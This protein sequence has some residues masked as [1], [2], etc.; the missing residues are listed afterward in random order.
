[1]IACSRVRCDQQVTRAIVPSPIASGGVAEQFRT[2]LELDAD[3]QY[4]GGS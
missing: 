4:R 3:R 2:L 1:M